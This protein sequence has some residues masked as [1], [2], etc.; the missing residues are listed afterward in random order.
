VTFTTIVTK[1][2]DYGITLFA[3]KNLSR[4]DKLVVSFDRYTFSVNETYG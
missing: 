2:V 4:M 3:Y 1:R